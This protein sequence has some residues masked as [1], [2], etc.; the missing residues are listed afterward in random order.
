M[1]VLYGR[2]YVNGLTDYLRGNKM[3]EDRT[4]DPLCPYC[5]SPVSGFCPP[6]KDIKSATIYCSSAKC[7]GM[8]LSGHM[9]GYDIKFT[10]VKHRGGAI[11]YPIKER[12]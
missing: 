8:S 3:K 9:N 5:F 6:E 12:V 4:D 2:I 10:D 11:N 1:G 7:K